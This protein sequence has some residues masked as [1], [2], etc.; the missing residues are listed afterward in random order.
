MEN[1]SVLIKGIRARLTRVEF[2]LLTYLVRNAGKVL[3]S[4]QIL[5]AVWGVEYVHIYISRLRRKL[6]GNTKSPR[7]FLTVHGW[8]TFLK[9]R[10]L[11][12][13]LAQSFQL[14]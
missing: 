10:S 9:A 1:H 4:N 3:T 11:C 2:R 7:Y 8:D 6:E 13:S 12:R 14:E 5:S